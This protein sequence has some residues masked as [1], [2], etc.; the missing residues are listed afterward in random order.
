MITTTD[1]LKYGITVDGVVHT[2]FEMRC[3]VIGDNIAAVEAVGT[4]SNLRVQVAMMSR[5]LVKLGT[6]SPDQITFDLL[7]NNL[8]DDDFDVLT[9][10]EREL[11][12]K[13]LSSSQPSGAIDS[14]SPSSDATD[15]PKTESEQ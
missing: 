14:A 15:S 3:P 10:A 9:R 2:D 7:S 12:K 8:V 13:L 1:K 11:K 5:T 6:L 4:S